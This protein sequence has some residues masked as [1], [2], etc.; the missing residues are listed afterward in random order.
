[1][2]AR[3]NDHCHDRR[4]FTLIEAL[5][6]ITLF[7]SAAVVLSSAFVNALMA[8]EFGN[9]NAMLEGDIRAVRLQL[10]LEPNRED[11]E[12]GNDIDTMNSGKASWKAEIEPTSVV[13][14]FQ[15]NFQIEFLDPPENQPASYSE[16]LYLLRPSWSEGDKRSELL[17]EKREAL[18]DSR[19]FD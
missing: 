6:A 9:H 8:R 17:E 1:M 7:A 19:D 16:I 3:R 14:L 18:R 15:V 12:D 5:L 10:L 13:D 2:R 4:A 11:A